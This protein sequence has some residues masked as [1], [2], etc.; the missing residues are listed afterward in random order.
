MLTPK[1]MNQLAASW[2]RTLGATPE[3]IHARLFAMKRNGMGA[4]GEYQPDPAGDPSDPLT[5]ARKAALNSFMLKAEA[6]RKGLQQRANS[7]LGLDDT[8][9]ILRENQEL[10]QRDYNPSEIR[11]IRSYHGNSAITNFLSGQAPGR[12]ESPDTINTPGYF[13]RNLV[14][15]YG[16]VVNAPSQIASS[17]VGKNVLVGVKSAVSAVN[18]NPL[19]KF[20]HKYNDGFF[21]EEKKTHPELTQEAAVAGIPISPEG[22]LK[23]FNGLNQTFGG[24]QGQLINNAVD[25]KPLWQGVGTAAMN[26]AK[27]SFLGKGSTTPYLGNSLIKKGMLKDPN[28]GKTYSGFAVPETALEMT[29]DLSSVFGLKPIKE[30][31]EAF[32]ALQEAEKL[33]TTAEG[34]A[35][36]DSIYQ[37]L[38]LAAKAGFLN[39]R[40]TY[41]AANKLVVGPMDR[42]HDTIT[43]NPQIDQIIKNSKIQAGLSRREK[44]ANPA[45]PNEVLGATNQEHTDAIQKAAGTMQ[46][47]FTNNG[48]K[49]A[50]VTFINKS[51]EDTNATMTAAALPP[52]PAQSP[53]AVKSSSQAQKYRQAAQENAPV[54][55]PQ[56]AYQ[57]TPEYSPFRPSPAA[58]GTPSSIVG[59]NGLPL[60]NATAKAIVLPNGTRV[61]QPDIASLPAS[62]KHQAPDTSDPLGEKDPFET[63][64]KPAPVSSDPKK[65][66]EGLLQDSA[67]N[68]RPGGV[69]VYAPTLSGK[70]YTTAGGYEGV[71]HGGG[72]HTFEGQEVPLATSTPGSLTGH[73]NKIQN[74]AAQSVDNTPGVIHVAAGDRGA[75]LSDPSTNEHYFKNSQGAMDE[76]RLSPEQ[77]KSGMVASLTPQV[78]RP[79][80][81]NILDKVKNGTISKPLDLLPYISQLGMAE[82][83]GL[84]KSLGGDAMGLGNKPGFP[85]AKESIDTTIDPRYSPGDLMGFIS[86]NPDAVRK[87]N[88]G[89]SYP[90]AIDSKYFPYTADENGNFPN[91]H[92]HF[93]VTDKRGLM[94]QGASPADTANK[95]FRNHYTITPKTDLTGRVDPSVSAVHAGFIGNGGINNR[96]DLQKLF[97][98]HFIIGTTNNPGRTR[99]RL[100]NNPASLTDNTPNPA[101]AQGTEDAAYSGKTAGTNS[102]IS[103]I[104][105]PNKNPIQIHSVLKSLFDSGQKTVVYGDGTHVGEYAIEGNN[106]KGFSVRELGKVPKDQVVFGDKNA[107]NSTRI[108]YGNGNGGDTF[109]FPFPHQEQS[110][111][112]SVPQST[113]GLED[114]NKSYSSLK[115][116]IK[117]QWEFLK[118]QGVKMEP[119]TQE[120][121][122]YAN[123]KE[124]QKDAES[125]HL[126]FFTGGDMA[127]AH[128]LAEK[129]PESGLTYN[130]MLR[131]VHDYFGH[132]AEGNQFGANGEENAWQ[133]HARMFPKEALPALTAE[134]R[135]QNSFVNFGPHMRDSS[136]NLLPDTDPAYLKAQHRPFSKQ[137]AFAAPIKYSDP[138]TS[139]AGSPMKG[140]FPDNEPAKF[141]DKYIQEKGLNPGPK[142]SVRVDPELA[143]EM[144]DYQAAQ[145]LVPSG[146]DNT[147]TL[148]KPAT[149][150]LQNSFNEVLANTRNLDLSKPFYNGSGGY[151]VLRDGSIKDIT[152]QSHDR[153]ANRAMQGA[154]QTGTTAEAMQKVADETGAVRIRGFNGAFG[155]EISGPITPQQRSALANFAD[156]ANNSDANKT[157]TPSTFYYNGQKGDLAGIDK[158]SNVPTY[159]EPLGKPGDQPQDYKATYGAVQNNPN[160]GYPER[161]ISVS[162]SANFTDLKHELAHH[163]WQYSTPGEQANITSLLD[164]A[165]PQELADARVGRNVSAD[166]PIDDID[167]HELFANAAENMKWGTDPSATTLAGKVKEGV[168][169]P[170]SRLGRAVRS[171]V[172]LT[173]ELQ[174]SP[175]IQNMLLNYTRDNPLA[176]PM[177]QSNKIGMDMRDSLRDAVSSIS[178]EGDKTIKVPDEPIYGSLKGTYVS[179]KD[180]AQINS[181]FK[182]NTYYLPMKTGI[183]KTP[184]GQTDAPTG[185]YE[186]HIPSSWANM[187]R[188]G[189]GFMTAKSGNAGYYLHNFEGDNL[190]AMTNAQFNGPGAIRYLRNL[191]TGYKESLIGSGT[192]TDQLAQHSSILG[193]GTQGAMAGVNEENP[194]NRFQSWV[195][196]SENAPKIALFKT[197][198]DSGMAPAD[199]AEKVAKSQIDYGNLPGVIKF[200]SQSGLSSF[201]NYGY[202]STKFMLTTLA[203]NPVFMRRLGQVRQSQFNA[204]PGSQEQY[205]NARDYQQNPGVIPTS[206]DTKNGAI[207]YS[208]TSPMLPGSVNGLDLPIPKK[209]TFP[210]SATLPGVSNSVGENIN[211]TEDAVR[212]WATQT[213]LVGGAMRALINQNRYGELIN[214]DNTPEGIKGLKDF[215]EAAS[216]LYPTGVSTT[217]ERLYDSI[218]GIPRIQKGGYGSVLGGKDKQVESYPSVLGHWLGTPTEFQTPDNPY[219]VDYMKAVAGVRAAGAKYKGEAARGTV[220]PVT[221]LQHTQALADYEAAKVKYYGPEGKPREDPNEVYPLAPAGSLPS[222]DPTQQAPLVPMAPASP[223]NPYGFSPSL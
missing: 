144:A 38:P 200:A 160:T 116:G 155:A 180:M 167:R 202:A 193:H 23:A 186:G 203:Q 76:G 158:N 161:P 151:Y 110:P 50:P 83:G 115:S 100:S 77:F 197:F 9:R 211:S 201:A 170:M 165:T 213:P 36:A 32:K 122:P 106:T 206:A 135:M 181:I 126:S 216:G 55:T 20:Y 31:A 71:V 136:G 137:S 56:A 80:I 205:Q 125:G 61:V 6:N 143:K 133:A 220:S 65:N 96:Q 12:L 146:S 16:S 179:P 217:G 114:M 43:G 63:L 127:S 183:G 2:K 49:F 147:G 163:L 178:S 107:P 140:Q 99:T 113:L 187:V 1:Q 120:G 169:D 68:P 210:Q 154:G 119:W 214:D 142:Q 195:Q 117:D 42:I 93:D 184:P 84:L 223:P 185:Q 174:N 51:Q 11:S 176:N 78:N 153:V 218:T 69:A 90:H 208:D 13:K 177:H 192:Y 121:Q 73:V 89:P 74:S 196:A 132:A 33:G 103:S 141:S 215:N 28:S 46:G 173:N 17:P 41:T 131:A 204:Y 44:L 150:P 48:Q 101:F 60:N 79:A 7:L 148:G 221:A 168:I 97:D 191:P 18:N 72:N 67:G 171:R 4:P 85:T 149:T 10:D 188:T 152:G 14:H 53:V 139:I 95:S 59:P 86:G 8:D 91:L 98:S 30:G 54:D 111:M 5:P 222:T 105:A 24:A 25:N 189:K 212:N 124:M 52:K 66:A 209:F 21:D 162:P 128:P 129:D 35:K 26:N 118:K 47:H 94:F 92:D 58:T 37:G 207:N 194:L 134:T 164:K 219:K 172:G 157:L 159:S 70:P 156:A 108:N 57:A 64:G 166:A 104:D 130:D 27:A 87:M 109:H 88:G 34:A 39:A 123:S 145:P 82:R 29:E 3:E 45:A 102:V 199:A 112:A 19:V 15:N 22:A 75:M 190:A 62:P 182:D 175:Q 198:V 81:A 138:A 40:N